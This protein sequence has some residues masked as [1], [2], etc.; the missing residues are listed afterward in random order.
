MD[1][2][3]CMLDQLSAMESNLRLASKGD[4]KIS[5]HRME[6][7]SPGVST[8]W[9][10]SVCLSQSLSLTLSVCLSQSLS[11]TLSLPVPVSLCPPLA[12]CL[13]P[14]LS[15]SVCLSVCLSLSKVMG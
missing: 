8:T 3:D 9:T 2:L 15:P 14:P 5:L 10:F 6:V 13:S 11:L 1:L 4:L 7:H 12:V